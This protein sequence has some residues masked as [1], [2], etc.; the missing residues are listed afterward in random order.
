MINQ[1][2]DQILVLYVVRDVTVMNSKEMLNVLKFSQ[3]ITGRES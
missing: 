3:T 2:Y 1:E